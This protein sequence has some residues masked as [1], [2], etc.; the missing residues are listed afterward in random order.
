[1]VPTDR[2]K[3]MKW[4]RCAEFLYQLDHRAGTKVSPGPQASDPAAV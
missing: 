4:P 2:E 3:L 1:M